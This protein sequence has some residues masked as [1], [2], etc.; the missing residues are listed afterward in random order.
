MAQPSKI[1]VNPSEQASPPPPP[2]KRRALL[3]TPP[4]PPSPAATDG[5][6]GDGGDGGDD[7]DGHLLALLLQLQ[8]Q[9]TLCWNGCRTISR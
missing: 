2:R 4:S 1:Q 5:D 8:H 7:D 6:D 3:E 9:R